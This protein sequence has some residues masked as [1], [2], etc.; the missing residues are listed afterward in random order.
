MTTPAV[1]ST[2]VD[3]P[4]CRL[5]LGARGGHVVHARHI[6]LQR[7]DPCSALQER[8]DGADGAHDRVRF[9]QEPEIERPLLPL[10]QRVASDEN[11]RGVVSVDEIGG[12]RQSDIAEAARQH[13]D[14]ARTEGDARGR[15][16]GKGEPARVAPPPL[17]ITIG[18]HLAGRIR[19]QVV[20]QKSR[21]VRLGREG[22]GPADCPAWPGS[23]SHLSVVEVDEADGD[24]GI[25]L[26]DHERGAEDQRLFRIGQVF[27]PYRLHAG[28][29]DVHV[30]RIG[31][32]DGVERPNQREQAEEAGILMGKEPVRPH[33]DRAHRRDQEG[34]EDACRPIPVLLD[35]VQQASIGLLAIFDAQAVLGR[36]EPGKGVGAPDGDDRMAEAAQPLQRGRGR[37]RT[38]RQGE[39]AARL[40]F[41]ERFGIG[42]LPDRLETPIGHVVLPLKLRLGA[43]FGRSRPFDEVALVLEGIGGQGRVARAQPR[44]RIDIET[45]RPETAKGRE[46]GEI[47]GDLFGRVRQAVDDL[48][49]G[50]PRLQLGHRRQDT[51]RPDF[52]IDVLGVLRQ[53]SQA[54]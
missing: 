42:R 6:G 35:R 4:E 12:E 34:V 53:Q 2:P 19:G 49:G 32:A 1:C 23:R 41:C 17:S 7:Q 11:D 18:N 45:H 27:R 31:H 26:G 29:H 46:E 30:H 37:R 9:R 10:R 22:R 33:A 51:T 16:F 52:E 13:V 54:G 28:G 15:A 3:R 20:P 5:G 36:G 47:V 14:A 43:G 40:G 38:V 21:L 48:I 25:F 24:P 50:N 39:P 44:R 8:R